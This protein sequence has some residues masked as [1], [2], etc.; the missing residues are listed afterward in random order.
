MLKDKIWK[1]SIT[2]KNLKQKMVIKE[3][4]WK[5]KLKKKLKGNHK[6]SI[7]GLN[8]KEK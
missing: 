3:R 2:Q 6:F 4:E 1:K 7:R 8:G 5:L